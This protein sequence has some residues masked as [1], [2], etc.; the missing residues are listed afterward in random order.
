MVGC[1]YVWPIW[2]H[3]TGACVA[4]FLVCRFT[5]WALG[6]WTQH[7][8]ILSHHLLALYKACFYPSTTASGALHKQHSS[9]NFHI[10]F[11]LISW[12]I[13]NSYD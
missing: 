13:Q 2:L 12:V 3:D 6:C 1:G 8:M 7:Y 5:G 11:I 9:H 10:N 4:G